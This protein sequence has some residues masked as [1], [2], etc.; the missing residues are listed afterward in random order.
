MW[1]D[2]IVVVLHSKLVRKKLLSLRQISVPIARQTSP[3]VRE[4]VPYVG[5][6]SL[7]ERMRGKMD[8]GIKNLM[9]CSCALAVAHSSLQAALV[10]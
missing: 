6:T 2:V 5:L 7:L 9:N 1:S 10:V 4:P 3:R 8:F